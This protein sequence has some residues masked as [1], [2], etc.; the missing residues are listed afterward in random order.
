MSDYQR[1]DSLNCEKQETFSC[2]RDGFKCN[3]ELAL[4]YHLINHAKKVLYNGENDTNAAIDTSTFKR[5][6]KSVRDKN[7]NV[8][9]EY[10]DPEFTTSSEYSINAHV[11]KE[12]VEKPISI[13]LQSNFSEI[14]KISTLSQPTTAGR[15][16]F[17]YRRCEFVDCSYWATDK[18]EMVNHV[19]VMHTKTK[20][21]SSS[22]PG[23]SYKAS[24]SNKAVVNNDAIR[25]TD[26]THK[27]PA[28]KFSTSL[29]KDLRR[30]IKSMHLQ[31]KGYSCS[32]CSFKTPLNQA[33]LKHA[34]KNHASYYFNKLRDRFR[35]I[36]KQITNGMGYVISFVEDNKSKRLKKSSTREHGQEIYSEKKDFQCSMCNQKSSST[37]KLKRHRKY[38][39]KGYCPRDHFLSRQDTDSPLKINTEANTKSY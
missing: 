1:N 39:K 38:C 11:K 18:Y 36:P 7:N 8:S 29:K 27:C 21:L 23:C 17:K 34:K 16:I 35:R 15:L 31:I 30:H 5:H 20:E 6:S 3:S 4:S 9:S 2:I 37:F 26:N 24:T 13:Q 14:N 22:K 33:L 32:L 12:Y 19:N 10:M 25:P 28:C